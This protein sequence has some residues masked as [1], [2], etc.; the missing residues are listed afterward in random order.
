MDFVYEKDVARR[1]IGE[2]GSQVAHALY[3][4]AGSGLYLRS[5]LFGYQK[6]EGGFA[7][8]S[9]AV[10]KQMLY[11][12]FS[13]GSGLNKDAEVLFY[14]LLA[15]VFVPFLRPQ[16]LIQGFIQRSGGFDIVG[17]IVLGA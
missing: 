1:K 15:D 14:H 8:S 9:R 6:S 2:N 5:Q 17:I 12:L 3:G 13:L 4:R 10:K 7:Q 16:G 11:A